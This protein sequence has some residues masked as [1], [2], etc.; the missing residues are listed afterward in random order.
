[1][2]SFIDTSALFLKYVEEGDINAFEKLLNK[3][4]EII[5]SPITVLEIQSVV[6]KKLHAKEITK[7][8]SDI[9]IKEFH[10]DL[11]FFVVVSWSDT[12]ID[13]ATRQIKTHQLKTLDSIQLASAIV[14]KPDCFITRD[15]Q[16][17]KKAK[18]ELSLVHYLS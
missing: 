5:I 16:L 13:E 2:K 7:E 8:E 15:K 4:S 18:K 10:S 1:M 11:D 12:L 6:T 3:T 17:S 14:V 9:I